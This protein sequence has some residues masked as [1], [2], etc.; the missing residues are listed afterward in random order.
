MKTDI[1]IKKN[2]VKIYEYDCLITMQKGD[3]VLFNGIEHQVECCILE[4]DAKKMLI[5][6]KS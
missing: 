2:W 5:L 1:I 3:I 4:I 6:L